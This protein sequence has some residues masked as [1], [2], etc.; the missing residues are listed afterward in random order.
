MSTASINLNEVWRKTQAEKRNWRSPAM[1]KA[2]T[3]SK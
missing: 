3:I 1:N 2:S